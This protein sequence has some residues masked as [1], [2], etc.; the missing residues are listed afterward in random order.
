VRR[1]TELERASRA[2]VAGGRGGS[3]S[4]AWQRGRGERERERLIW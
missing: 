1:A 2:I 3:K 4:D